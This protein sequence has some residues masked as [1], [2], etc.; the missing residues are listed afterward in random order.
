MLEE[1]DYLELRSSASENKILKY[2]LIDHTGDVGV[3][4]SGK[5][6]EELFGNAA[7][8]L[9]DIITDAER[10]APSSVRDINLEANDLDQL[11]VVWLNELLY[12]FDTERWLFGSFKIDALSERKIRSRAEGEKFDTE[13]HPIKT[14]VK[15]VTYH[16]LKI[17]EKEGLWKTQIVFDL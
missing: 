6:R 7:Y 11:L 4:V 9:F 13:R 15:A 2:K 1:K 14:E 3:E 16:G 8:A 12:L 5:T 17:E 10:I